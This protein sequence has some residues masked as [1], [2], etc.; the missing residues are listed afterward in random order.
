MEDPESDQAGAR[1]PW[2]PSREGFDQLGGSLKPLADGVDL[3]L[4]GQLYQE[5]AANVAE[6]YDIPF[7]ALHFYPMRP[8][9]SDRRFRRVIARAA[10]SAR[11]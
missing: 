6:Y 7:A 1:K 4:T 9:G 8:N 10:E 5:I 11:Q 3:L 2:S